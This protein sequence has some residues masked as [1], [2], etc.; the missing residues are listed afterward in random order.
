MEPWGKAMPLKSN[1]L[2]ERNQSL[3]WPLEKKEG[4]S[5]KASG[6]RH[7]KIKTIKRAQGIR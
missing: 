2:M 1:R 3:V 6:L 5:T 7:K 4:H